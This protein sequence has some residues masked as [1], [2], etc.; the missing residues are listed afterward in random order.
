MIV[1]RVFK[2]KIDRKVEGSGW[3]YRKGVGFFY[4]EG[5]VGIEGGLG[6]VGLERDGE[7]SGWL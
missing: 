4:V 6:G 5:S 3:E 2:E 1:L 7:G